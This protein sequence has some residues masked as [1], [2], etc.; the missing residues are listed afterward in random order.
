MAWDSEPLQVNLVLDALLLIF[1]FVGVNLFLGLG[2]RLALLGR[3]LLIISARVRRLLRTLA[4]RFG[5]LWNSNQGIAVRNGISLEG[6]F[7]FD[8]LAG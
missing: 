3:A 6:R 2:S 1:G 5:S 4:G 7:G 8:C